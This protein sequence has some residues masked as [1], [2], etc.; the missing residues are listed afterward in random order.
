MARQPNN[1]RMEH[2]FQA[3]SDYPGV[4]PGRIAEILGLN[5]SEVTRLLPAMEL[6]GY[7]L[8]EDERGGLWPYKQNRQQKW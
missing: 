5:R 7:L 6:Q 8:A 2:V 3:V 1:E 4:R